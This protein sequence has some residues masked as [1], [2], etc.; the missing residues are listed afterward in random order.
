MFK[1]LGLFEEREKLFSHTN[2]VLIQTQ[3][4]FKEEMI[5]SK[6]YVVKQTKTV[7]DLILEKCSL[8]KLDST[9]A[10]NALD[11]SKVTLKV[12]ECKEIA[13]E[14]DANEQGLLCLLPKSDSSLVTEI[15]RRQTNC[16]ET[17]KKRA[18]LTEKHFYVA[19]FSFDQSKVNDLVSKFAVDFVDCL[20][21]PTFEQEKIRQLSERSVKLNEEFAENEQ[22]LL[23]RYREGEKIFDFEQTEDGLQ[24]TCWKNDQDLIKYTKDDC[25]FEGRS[26]VKISLSGSVRFI[27]PVADSNCVFIATTQS[28]VQYNMQTAEEPVLKP[29]INWNDFEYPLAIHDNLGVIYWDLES[30]SIKASLSESMQL[31]C[32]TEPRIFCNHFGHGFEFW[33]QMNGSDL[34]FLNPMNLTTLII[35]FSLHHFPQI[36]W[37]HLKSSEENGFEVTLLALWCCSLKLIKVFKKKETDQNFSI[38]EVYQ[39]ESDDA[40]SFK[41]NNSSESALDPWYL[42]L[43]FK[44]R[45]LKENKAGL[46]DH[47]NDSLDGFIVL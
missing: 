43:K 5:L 37:I 33:F 27:Q 10:E 15:K 2:D 7:A 36:D 30:R 21:L 24:I 14:S 34:I 26:V 9:N 31:Q 38:V 42:H 11:D 40:A 47:S 8:I 6:D 20:T 35:P 25:I 19:P 41:D 44:K 23:S 28:V 18:R 13:S 29:E 46:T 32:M 12:N 17:I 16:N 3:T 1:L 45:I 22:S 4:E 39:W